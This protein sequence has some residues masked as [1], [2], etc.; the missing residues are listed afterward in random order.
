[1]KLLKGA[2]KVVEV[3]LNIKPWEKVLVLTDKKMLRFGKA[4]Y[5][6]SRK[7]NLETFLLV[8]EPLGRDGAEPPQL[9]ANL[10][11]ACNV[12]IAPTYYSLT[13]TRARRE[14]CKNGARIATMPCIKEFSF[15]KGG[16]TAD[17]EF[18]KKLVEKIY[19]KIKGSSFIQV[20]SRNGT[21]VSF[22]VKGREWYKDT[23]FIHNPGEFGNLP[24]G[25]VFIAPLEDSINGKIVFDF[26]ELARGKVKLKVED[27]KIEEIKGCKKLIEIFE[28]FEKARQI[29][30]FG[31]G[32][33]PKS[34]IIGSALED[35]KVLGTIH[36]ALGNN[37]GFGGRNEVEFHKDGIIKRPIVKIDDEIIIEKGKWRF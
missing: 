9:V 26:F 30:E 34:K 7:I 10:M 1:M 14:A 36:F 4:L 20:K 18:V 37:I 3:C 2:R 15:V 29:A 24:G 35:E 19:E 32:C 31:I 5:E 12:I 6:V 33:N 8:M 21:E 17:Y 22:S 13:H 11:K 23:G 16:L 28:V 25:E 27:G